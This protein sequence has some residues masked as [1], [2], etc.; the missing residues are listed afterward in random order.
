M[1]DIILCATQRCGSTMI[2]EDMRNTGVL[3]RPEEWF[4][5]WK[6]EKE[7]VSWRRSLR[8]IRRRG[9]GENDVF[10]VKVMANQ[11]ASIEAC[12]ATLD[13]PGEEKPVVP[14]AYP[15]FADTFRDAAW[16]RIVRRDVV[17]QAISR[18]MSRQT[19]INHA[20]GSMEDEHFA[21]NLAKGYDPAYNDRTV[22]RFEAILK[23]V[24]A[25]VLENLTWD[26]FF[27]T[28]GITPTELIYEEVAR[29]EGMGHLDVMAERVG[30]TEAPPRKP[31]V[32]VKLGNEKNKEWRDHFFADAAEKKFHF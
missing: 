28:S 4:L 10:A 30:L 17:S 6:P 8:N 20:T 21:G 5:P 15:R 29:D 12:L 13:E 2:V 23:H 14:G 3:G 1:K 25:I 9:T 18:V 22:Y 16:I 7:G 32:M 24:T 11:V 19:G 31:R 27:E 26:R